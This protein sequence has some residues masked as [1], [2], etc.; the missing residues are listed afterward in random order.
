MSLIAPSQPAWR[1]LGAGAGALL[2]AACTSTPLPPQP[3]LYPVGPPPVAAAPVPVPPPPASAPAPSPRA[4]FVRPSDGPV[5]GRFD[6]T[7]NKGLDIGG[8]LGDA[9]VAAADGRV[10]IVSKELRGYGTML[11]LKHGDTF[12]TAYAHL[13]RALVKENDVVRQGQKIAEM[14]KTGTDRVKVHFE[15]RKQGTAVDPEPYL[16]GLQH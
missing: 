10:V 9:V 7:R 15:I 12:I 6:G 3:P 8:T 16:Q 14:G 2:L 13:D 1:A 4:S 5:V 11:I